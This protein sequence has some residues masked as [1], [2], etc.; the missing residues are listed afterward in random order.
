MRKLTCCV[1]VLLAT[2]PNGTLADDAP[3]ARTKKIVLIAGA[4]DKNH[5]PGTHEY[6]K[7]VRLLKRCLDESANMKGLRVET[8]FG[9]W[10]KDEKTLDDAD[11]IVLISSGSDRVEKDHPLLVGERLAVIGKQMKRGC[12]LV[13]IHWTTFLPNALAG[14]KALEWIGGHFDYQ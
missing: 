3:A 6:E 1:I 12:G 2:I 10:P 7:S 9:G 8:H 11:T 5:P 13:A 4:L 14:E